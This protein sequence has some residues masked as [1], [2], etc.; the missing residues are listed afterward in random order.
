[1]IMSHTYIS[2]DEISLT[3]FKK[4]FERYSWSALRS[5]LIAGLA[6]SM[7]TLPQ[8]LAYALVAG[9]PVSAGLY[10]AIFSSIIMAFFGSSRHLIVGPSNAIAILI[11]GG[12][13]SILFTY[14]RDVVG[15]EKDELVLQIL[16]QLMLL[17]GTIQ[18]IAAFLKLGRLTH[19]VSHT[20]IIGYV[21]G[22]ALAL[23]I[24]QLFPLLG[25]DVPLDVTSLY[26]RSIYILTHLQ[27]MHWP[28]ALIGVSC[29]LFL[30]GLKRIDSKMPVGAI[31]L[32]SVAVLA[33]F[34]GYAYHYFEINQYQFLDWS[35]V[36]DLVHNI[37]IVG[38]TKGNGFIPSS[39]G[40]ILIPEL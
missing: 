25:M 32:A 1:M 11:Q 2:Q 39:T 36:E 40:L 21:S 19:F 26:E 23:V 29:L 27:F 9:L 35:Q 17:V 6:V 16:T 10:A 20:V 5:D 7:L 8:S 24:N 15:P 4:D 18:I 34:I 3:Y 14:Y 37:A 22:V 28:T 30:I 13:S 31:M 38:D 12:I 33:Y